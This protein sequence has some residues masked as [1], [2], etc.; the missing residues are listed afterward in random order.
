MCARNDRTGW[1]TPHHTHTHA[2]TPNKQGVHGFWYPY[3]NVFRLVEEDLRLQPFTDWCPSA[4]Y[5]PNGLEVTSPIFQVSRSLAIGGELMGRAVGQSVGRWLWGEMI[6]ASGSGCV[7]CAWLA[8]T[9]PQPHACVRAQDMPRLPTPL[10]TFLYPRFLRLP[11]AD[12]ARSVHTHIHTHR[13]VGWL[14]N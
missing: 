5:S 3:R 10:G 8:H 9:T 12:R 4:Q 1:L 14:V 2:L 11:W 7:A 13:L 6:W